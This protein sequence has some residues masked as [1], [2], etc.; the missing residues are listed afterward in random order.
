MTFGSPWFL[1][2]LLLVPATAVAA[3]WLE[4]RRARYTVAFT[5]LD[6]LASVAGAGRRRRLVAL[7][8]LVLFLLAV[9]TASAAV[10]R[11]RVALSEP[12]SQATVVLLVDVSGSMRA[13][14]V[15][16]SRLG[17][18]QEAMNLFAEKI[19]KSVKIGLV[20]FSIGPEV[21]VMPTTDRGQLEEGIDLLTPE[22]STALGDGIGEAVQ[23]VKEGV[24][25]A[26]RDKSGK[27]PGTIVLLSDGAQTSGTLTPLQGA[28]LAREAGIRVFT[29]VLGTNHGT[30]G[31]GGGG[32]FGFGFGGGPRRNVRPDPVTLAAIA[33]ETGGQTFRAKTANKVETV[34]KHLGQSV[35][36]RTVRR[37]VSSWFAAAAA[38]F[39]LASIAAARVAGGR[40]P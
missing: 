9:A 37:E 8:P 33:K 32:F 20:S 15:K 17:A 13:T 7:L 40:L 25:N 36:Q 24:G 31:G 18:A 34:Y 21:L 12:S 39:L 11:P 23:V 3:W 29:V 1:L 30:V 22:S 6:V 35:A 10:A 5:N 19:P 14:D 26:T 16:P 38:A 2:L 27:I 4:R 28:D